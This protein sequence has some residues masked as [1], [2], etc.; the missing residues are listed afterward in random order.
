[1][2]FKK[3]QLTVN[4]VELKINVYKAL[5]IDDISDDMAKVA[6]EM[7]F[8]GSVWAAAESE[9]ISLDGFYRG[10]RARAG[11]AMLSSEPKMSEWKIRQAIEVDKVFVE[12][13]IKIAQAKYNATLAKSVFEAFRV[14]ANQLQSA[15]AHKRAELDASGMNTPSDPSRTGKYK[16]ENE[17]GMAAMRAGNKG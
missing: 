11:E 16:A 14:K 6:S 7:G 5:L 17:D 15:G 3:V 8:W 13:K 9:V 4:G 12:W 1:M 2:G 10:W